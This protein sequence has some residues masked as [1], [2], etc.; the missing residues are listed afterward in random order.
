MS[1][2]NR[3]VIK[4]DIIH[5]PNNH[6][7][8]SFPG[9]YL[10]LV[11]GKIK[12][13]I[14]DLPVEHNFGKIDDY[15]DCLIIPGLIDIHIHAPQFAFRGVGM[16]LELLPWLEAYPFKEEARYGNLS[17]A[18]EAYGRFVEHLRRGAT[19][20]ACVFATVHG[21]ATRLLMDQ[22][23]GSGLITYVGKVNMDRNSPAALLETT[24]GSC[25]QT[26]AWLKASSAYLRTK[27]I[28]TPRFVPSCTERLMACLGRLAN[29][30]KVPVQSHLSENQDEVHWVK[31]LHPNLPHYAGVYDH[32]QLFGNV[33]P[34]IMAHCV[35]CTEAEIDLMAQRGIFIAHCP[36]SNTNLASGIAPIAKLMQRKIP[37]GLGT[38][39]AGGFSASI[40]RAMSDAIQVSKL[41]KV[42]CQEKESVLTLS[43]AFFLGTKGGGAFFGKV[44]SF[45][46][47]YEGDLLAIDDQGFGP[48]RHLSLEQRIER[49]VYLNEEIEI[50]AKYVQGE[51]IF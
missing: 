14:K 20:R 18:K 16:D 38:D 25:A 5:T 8:E 29:D 26:E 33:T 24:E 36:Q 49:A 44:G 4:G 35:Y 15:G 17:Y 39:V 27:P 47:D 41:R 9:H 11:D 1:R 13:I 45:E 32:F 46:R 3:H 51:R 48:N 10:V 34:A 6:R 31:E 37:I 40:F 50:K 30:Y 22:L 28:L 42:L 7:F 19:T 43:E 21:E 23:E 2:C 12:E